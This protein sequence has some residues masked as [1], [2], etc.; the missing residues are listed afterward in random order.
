MITEDENILNIVKILRTRIEDKKDNTELILLHQAKDK[1][2]L[3]IA[4]ELTFWEDNDLMRVTIG[5][6]SPIQ[7]EEEEDEL[8]LTFFD[9]R[10][11]DEF[12]L[13]GLPLPTRQKEEVVL[14]SVKDDTDYKN[15]EQRITCLGFDDVMR[16]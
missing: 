10:F 7:Q 4:D 14:I 13:N 9:G 2:N 8:K 6:E 11:T 15:L 3:V 5:I 12:L 16:M 1:D